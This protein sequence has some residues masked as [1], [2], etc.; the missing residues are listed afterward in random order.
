MNKQHLAKKIDQLADNVAKKG[1]YVVTKH[2]DYF[3]V[4]E[5]ITKNIIVSELPL[6]NI[7]DYL[8]NLRNKGKVLSVTAKR[9]LQNLL[10][11]YFKLRN[12]IM[13]YRNTLRLTKDNDLYHATSARMHDTSCRLTSVTHQLK[14]YR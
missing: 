10:D 14:K 6:R 12:D 7:A 9:N 11:Q 13:F 8:C 3:V 1:V 4:Q 2:N 5:H